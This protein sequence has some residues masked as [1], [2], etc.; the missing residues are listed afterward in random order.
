M[1]K[2]NIDKAWNKIL[3]AIG[4]MILGNL[5][6]QLS[7]A[8]QSA[9]DLVLVLD[10]SGSMK[11][12]DPEF[13][14]PQAIQKFIQQQ[15][16]QTQISVIIFDK[17]VNLSLPFIQVNEENFSEFSKSLESINYKGLYTDSPAA[18]ERAIYE[19]KNYGRTDSQKNIVFLTDG[20][21]DTGK[22]EFDLEKTRW[23][24]QE[25]AAD[26]VENAIKIFSI[27][28]TE[29]A[30]FQ[31]IQSLAQQTHGEYYRAMEASDL[32][33]AFS[34][35]STAINFQPVISETDSIVV[36]T[37]PA[38]E[39]IVEIETNISTPEDVSSEQVTLQKNQE[40]EL[41]SMIQA[42][43]DETNSKPYIEEPPETPTLVAED[44]KPITEQIHMETNSG[45]PYVLLGVFGLVIGG[46]VYW[47]YL[48]PQ[49]AVHSDE[50]YVSEAYLLDVHNH[51]KEKKY[52]LTETVTMVGRVE[53]SNNEQ[54][55]YIVIPETTIGRRHA[56]FE[57][58]DY[59]FWVID[60]GST[61]GTYVND[62]LIE[63]ATRL[64]DGD[65]V[66]FHKFEFVFEVPELQEDG[67]TEV[68]ATILKQ[69]V[70]ERAKELPE[71]QF[72]ITMQNS[73]LI[74]SAENEAITEFNS[75]KVSEDE[76][77]L[78][79]EDETILP[80]QAFDLSLEPQTDSED[81]EK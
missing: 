18:I 57:Y 68:S 67:I 8:N 69:A 5:F 65:R 12:N 74:Q 25:L 15:S 55:N 26:A 33:N 52:Q 42:E 20:I 72:D 24:K 32:E 77:I 80:E 13:I 36:S 59:S 19:L 50:F 31:L 4:L 27:G 43:S 81:P 51:T 54:I 40:P 76:F 44:I 21:V 58:R 46:L 49:W 71:P 35:I 63:T 78:D 30:D 61:N 6:S 34:K 28:F 9:L 29:N 10:N 38:N 75:V 70:N 48:R 66:R 64:K 22:P 56:L 23:L 16:E 62:K 53:P 41:S 37:E 7:Y 60:Q 39:E 79:S 47:L 2:K 3:F 14:V 11:K 45:L 73:D 17:N 1:F